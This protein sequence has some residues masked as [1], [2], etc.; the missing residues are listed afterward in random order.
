MYVY[1]LQQF[2]IVWNIFISNRCTGTII[3]ARRVLE[4]LLKEKRIKY[5]SI[6]GYWGLLEKDENDQGDALVPNKNRF[7][8]DHL[9]IDVSKV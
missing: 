6:K 8:I 4:P 5:Q 3:F 1:A 2:D 9:L 7:T